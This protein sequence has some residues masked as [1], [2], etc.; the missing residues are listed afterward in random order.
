MFIAL[1]IIPAQ[2]SETRDGFPRVCHGSLREN[3]LPVVLVFSEK[4]CVKSGLLRL[5]NAIRALYIGRRPTIY[6]KENQKVS[7]FGVNQTNLESWIPT[8]LPQRCKGD[9]KSV[10][11]TNNQTKAENKQETR[12]R[13]L[14]YQRQPLMG[15]PLMELSNRNNPVRQEHGKALEPSSSCKSLLQQSGIT[16]Y[17]KSEKHL[18]TSRG[19]REILYWSPP[20]GDTS[21]A[22]SGQRFIPPRKLLTFR[23]AYL[24]IYF[25]VDFS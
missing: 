24:R 13:N 9:S 25:R 10:S 2:T 12:R 16:I 15:L 21:N 8:I 6:D 11:Q 23:T 5:L 14:N 7:T 4:A 1:I 20:D 19:T 18:K 22:Y 17:P 3:V